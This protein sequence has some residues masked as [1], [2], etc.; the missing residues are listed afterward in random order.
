MSETLSSILIA[1]IC[2]TYLIYVRL[3]DKS[4]DKESNYEPISHDEYKSL[5]TKRN[6]ISAYDLSTPF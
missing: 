2:I 6:I 5:S 4:N 1:T 3:T